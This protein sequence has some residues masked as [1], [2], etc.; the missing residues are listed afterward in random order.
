M[1]LIALRIPVSSSKNELR[2][3]VDEALKKKW[4]LPFT[5]KPDL[6]SCKIV[7]QLDSQ[8]IVE[9]HGIFEVEPDSAGK[10][11]I[12]HFKNRHLHNKHIFI[13][14]YFERTDDK[15]L[16]ADLDKRRILQESIH[17]EMKL[18]AEGMEQFKR[19]Y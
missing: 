3:L 19:K 17:R 15:D 14:Q 11:L 12:N 10:W 8:G 7:E 18:S 16:S 9:H 13:R 2:H 1:K 6:C 5:T 4:C